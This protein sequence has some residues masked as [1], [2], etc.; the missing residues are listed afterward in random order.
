MFYAAKCYWPGVT[1][2]ELQHAA[3]RM[4]GEAGA[5][6]GRSAVEYIGSMLFPD[7]A[8]VLCLF[9]ASS[10]S[11]VQTASTRAGIPCDRVMESAWLGRAGRERSKPC[12]TS[13]SG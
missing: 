4:A 10:R 13:D 12:E 1:A 2:T 11:A 6:S 8:L 7:D 9:K 3:V 5:G